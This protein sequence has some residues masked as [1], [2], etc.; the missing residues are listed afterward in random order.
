MIKYDQKI[1]T[2]RVHPLGPVVQS[3]NF[4][5]FAE[6]QSW[7]SSYRELKHILNC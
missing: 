6:L 7:V 3:S 5:G 4:P 1:N 2:I